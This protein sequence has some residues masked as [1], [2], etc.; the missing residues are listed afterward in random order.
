MRLRKKGTYVVFLRKGRADIKGLICFSLTL[1]LS[2]FNS[3]DFA[4]WRLVCAALIPGRVKPGSALR[5]LCHGHSGS[6][7]PLLWKQGARPYAAVPHG[8]AHPWLPVWC[9]GWIKL[10][11]IVHLQR[12]LLLEMLYGSPHQCTEWSAT[13]FTFFSLPASSF[14]LSFLLPPTPVVCV[15]SLR[16]FTKQDFIAT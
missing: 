12:A 15:L 4:G 1:N 10:C 3:I 14:S 8:G 11:N 7:H 6:G 9:F 16:T 13:V 5:C 2:W